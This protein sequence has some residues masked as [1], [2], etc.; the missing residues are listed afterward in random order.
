M[1]NRGVKILTDRDMRSDLL[2]FAVEVGH[3]QLPEKQWPLARK[4]SP[5]FLYLDTTTEPAVT[6]SPGH[7][8]GYKIVGENEWRAYLLA[9]YGLQQL[10]SPCDGCKMTKQ[11]VTQAK[12]KIRNLQLTV[13]SLEA[14][15]DG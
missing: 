8:P 11:L 12:E 13:A 7:V 4:S 9:A 10:G 3:L 15:I 1:K 14:Q 5:H 6:L 2:K